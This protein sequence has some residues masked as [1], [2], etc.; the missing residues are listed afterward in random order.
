MKIETVVSRDELNALREVLSEYN[1]NNPNVFVKNSFGKEESLRFEVN[2]SAW[3][4]QKPDVAIEYAQKLVKSATV[5]KVL[6]AMNIV[7]DRS[8]PEIK[9]KDEWD[10]A[11]QTWLKII[12]KA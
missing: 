12:E 6:E 11:K 5:A 1:V 10:E 9:T 4:A 7:V 2:W 3:G 8:L